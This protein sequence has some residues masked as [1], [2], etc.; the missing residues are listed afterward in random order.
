MDKGLSAEP[1]F[2]PLPP[3]EFVSHG[4]PLPLHSGEGELPGLLIRQSVTGDRRRALAEDRPDGGAGGFGRIERL[5]PFSDDQLRAIG[6]D[7]I[8]R[9]LK[10][11]V[12]LVRRLVAGAIPSPVDITRLAIAPVPEG[13]FKAEIIMP[14]DESGGL[15]NIDQAVEFITGTLW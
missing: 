13:A 10:F 9:I 8:A 1:V 3:H 15:G 6:I 5:G 12:A 2:G 11:E 14:D 4:Y 7:R